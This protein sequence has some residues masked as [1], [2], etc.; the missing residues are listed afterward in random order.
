MVTP[1]QGLGQTLQMQVV[2]ATS[3]RVVMTMP[4]TA[5]HLQPWGYLHGGANVALAETAATAGAF[6]NCPAG[7]V[8]FGL[9]INAN[10]IRS[11]REGML[12]AWEYERF[13]SLLAQYQREEIM[14][15]AGVVEQKLEV[16][17]VAVTTAG[18]V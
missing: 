13:V 10:H 14:Q 5:Q 4:V 7:M 12:T 18:R 6:L 1:V 8:A 9:E 3:E 17:I 2:E 16:L 11:V 15:V